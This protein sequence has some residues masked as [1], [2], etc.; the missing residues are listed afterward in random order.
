MNKSKLDKAGLQANL[1]QARSVQEDLNELELAFQGEDIQI[2][3][4]IRSAYSEVSEALDHMEKKFE[5]DY[6]DWDETI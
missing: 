3:R 4:L 5:E 6:G 2:K 1:I